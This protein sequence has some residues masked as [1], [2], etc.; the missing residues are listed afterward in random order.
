MQMSA[1]MAFLSGPTVADAIGAEKNGLTQLV[2]T[3]PDDR[4]LIEEVY[5]RILARAPSEAEVEAAL[6]SYGEV[7]TDHTTLLGEL[8]QAE[9]DWVPVKSRREVTRL[10]GIHRANADITSYT[11]EYRQ[12]KTEA[13]A[14]Q[15]A[16]IATAN[17]AYEARIAEVPRLANDFAAGLS[18]SQFWTKWQV[19]PVKT[20]TASNKVKIDLLP[21]GSV[22]YSG[23]FKKGNID[24]LLTGDMKAQN[25]TGIMIEAIPDE[26]FGGFGPGLNPN[27]NF[28]I[29]E[30]QSRWHTTAEPAK[31]QPIAFADAV[32]DFNQNGFDVKNTING[33]LD[34]SAKG[35]ALGGSNHQTPHRALYRFREPAAG[36]SKGAE[37]VVRVI[38][39]FSQGDYPIGRFRVWYTTDADPLNFG[40]PATIAAAAQTSPSA[41]SKAQQESLATYIRENDEDL[42]KKKFAHL[43]EKRPL[44]ADQ[45]M[46]SLK[47]ALAQAELPIKEDPG[48]LQL[49]QDISYS[50]EQA[51]N[52]RLTAAQDLAWALI[53]NPSF[54][55]NR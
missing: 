44:P 46:E 50:T 52:R 33:K 40:L 39:R 47:A 25:V 36:D 6:Q 23:G 28:V 32:A 26:N 18:A 41:R 15:K 24:Y 45:T 20:A 17:K 29:S 31:H 51:A 53:N 10:R 14:N 5:Y 38:C 42:L 54:L 21:D 27:G 7:E 37:I 1:V 19:L 4:K 35:W 12:Q 48:L 3:E 55:F 9:A 43:K 49:R 16:R 30:V 13:E 34:P 2:D 8:A 11:P 22:R